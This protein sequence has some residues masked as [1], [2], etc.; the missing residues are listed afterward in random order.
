MRHRVLDAGVY[1]SIEADPRATK[2]A[3]AAVLLSAVASGIGASGLVGPRPLM[4]AAIFPLA[5][6]T[7]LAWAC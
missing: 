6:V 7:W 5:L 3:V 2:Q 1:E 4:L